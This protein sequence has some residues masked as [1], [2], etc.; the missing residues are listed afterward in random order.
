MFLVLLLFPLHRDDISLFA[1]WTFKVTIVTAI[2]RTLILGRWV[3]RACP[4]SVVGEGS[5]G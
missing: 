3:V 5:A 2:L 4:L 1:Y